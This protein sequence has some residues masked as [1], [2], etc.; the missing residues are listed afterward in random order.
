MLIN[1]HIENYAIIENLQVEF[2][3]GLNIITGETGAGKSII[4]G[5]LGLV[6]GERAD[7]T[8]LLDKQQKCVVEG[9]FKTQLPAVITFL[10]LHDIDN[11]EDIVIRRE[12]A[13]NGKS[14][15]FINDTPVNLTLLKEFSSH[16]VDLHQQ[17][18]TLELNDS[19]FQREVLDALAAHIPLLN[20][21][22]AVFKGYMNASKVLEKLKDEYANAIKENDY[23]N[24]L[25]SELEEAAFKVNEIEEAEEEIKLVSNS[26]HIKSILSNIYYQLS[27]SDQP[28]V[29]QLKSLNHQ[30]QSIKNFTQT[31]NPLADRMQDSYIELQDIADELDTLNDNIFYDVEKVNMLNERLSNGYRLFKKHSVNSTNDLLDVKLALALKLNKVVNLS[32]EITIKE[33][34]AEG[35]KAEATSLAEDISNNRHLQVSSL[36]QKVNKLLVKVGMPNAKIKIDITPSAALHFYGKDDIQFLFDANNT[37][38]FEQ[39]RKV[40]SGGELS[41]LMLIIKSLVAKSIQLPTLIFDEIDSGI[42]GEAARQVGIIMKE[43]SQAH[44]IIS[45]THQ[46]QIA[47]LANAHFFV[48]KTSKS[49]KVNTAVKL[50]TGDDRVQAIATMLSGE[51]PTEAAFKN[52]KEMIGV[53]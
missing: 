1:L 48:Y 11:Y 28:L 40:A 4:I 31:V 19:N 5:A 26:E 14:R 47:A 20:K 33:S 34:E 36:E 39:L 50:L 7:S 25:Y 13:A 52:A 45:I 22:Q 43:L 21:Y 10:E 42:S 30:L 18:D 6:L 32:E 41:R 49:G 24:F 12:I 29:Q 8:I 35:L 15:A 23:N 51:K 3:H 37:G 46:P 2:N 9:V 53:D 27:N 38:R 17:F 16:L 44:Q